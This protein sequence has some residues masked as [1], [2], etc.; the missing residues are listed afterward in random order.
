[1]LLYEGLTDNLFSAPGTWTLKKCSEL[2]CGTIWL[3]PMPIADDLSLAY[4]DYYTHGEHSS[5]SLKLEIAKRVYRSFVDIFLMLGNV[6]AERKR[7][8]LMFLGD[9]APAS[10]LDIGCGQGSFLG[11]MAKRGW[12][13]M[14]VDFD[15]AAVEAAHRLYGVDVRVGTVDT[16][17][18]TGIRFDVVTA[19][20]VIEHVPDPIAFL[21]K[22][23]SLLRPGGR[24]ILR[25]PNVDSIGHRRYRRHWR[26]LE[27]P[28]H[29]HLFTLAAL[30]ACALKAGFKRAR[31]FTTSVG[32]EGIWI[33]SHIAEKKGEFRPSKLTK[34]EQ[35][36]VKLLGPVLALRGKIAWLRDANSGEEIC[37]ELTNA[38]SATTE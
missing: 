32:A 10:L 37:A 14:G 29:L 2:G 30:K 7:A 8:A 4:I 21:S 25:T 15:A 23:R 26:G 13:V 22:C 16:M 24:M 5:R 38:A 33:A 20:H 17:I 27:P 35:L 36:E 1:V 9:Q 19:S 6:T 3:D 31:C 11:L 28:R 18:A 12:A 34:V